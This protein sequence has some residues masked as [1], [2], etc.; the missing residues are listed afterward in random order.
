MAKQFLIGTI[1]INDGDT[2]GTLILPV[3]VTASF[4][5]VGSNVFING[6]NPVQDIRGTDTTLTF[7]EQWAGGNLVNSPFVA[8]F[9]SEGLF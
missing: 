8:T 7:N 2:I 5:S 3:G 4:I 9:S 6:L 1:T